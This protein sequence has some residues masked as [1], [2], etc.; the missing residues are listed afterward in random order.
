MSRNTK[1]A[2]QDPK[3]V[4][5]DACQLVPLTHLSLDLDEP[6]AGW[7]A[8]LAG[9]QVEVVEDD[10]GRPSV[11]RRVLGELLADREDQEARMAGLRAELAARRDPIPAGVPALANATAFE[12]LAA[13]GMVTVA[14]EFGRVPK[15]NFVVES[16]DAGRKQVAD[17]RAE[18]EAVE[19]ARKLLEADKE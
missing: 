4:A 7:A 9:R 14:Q 16:L 5:C 1:T 17:Q 13:A 18:H 10:L 6:T 19:Q 11:P 8:M 2:V 12:S 3:V 15:P